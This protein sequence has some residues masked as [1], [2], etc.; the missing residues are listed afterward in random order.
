MFFRPAE[1]QRSSVWLC[2]GAG[3][4]QGW[5]CSGDNPR[6]SGLSPAHAGPDQGLGGGVVLPRGSHPDPSR[7]P[8]WPGSPARPP[9]DSSL[10]LPSEAA[11][12]SQLNLTERDFE[13]AVAKA[14]S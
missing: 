9:A 3:G 11:D 14:V 1:S 12:Q 8:D 6:L 10:Q 4:W 5:K 7:A 13:L 2:R